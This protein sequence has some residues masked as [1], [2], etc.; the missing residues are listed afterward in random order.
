[1]GEHGGRRQVESGA[2][3]AARPPP[4]LIEPGLRQSAR[5]LNQHCA[6]R[7]TLTRRRAS[8]VVTLSRIS[9]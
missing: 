3:Q 6:N 8:R 4:R 9:G 7:N 5:R 2:D 1:M